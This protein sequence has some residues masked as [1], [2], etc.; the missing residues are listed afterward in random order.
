M[1]ITTDEEEFSLSESERM[2]LPAKSASSG[3]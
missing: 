2:N 1:D 3:Y